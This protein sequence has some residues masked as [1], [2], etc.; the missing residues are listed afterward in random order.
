MTKINVGSM[1]N[2]VVVGGAVLHSQVSAGSGDPGHRFSE[3]RRA[4]EGI[5]DATARQ[6]LVQSA[7]DL[8]S[9]AGTPGFNDK[10]K[11]F[12]QLAADH[13]TVVSPFLPW[14]SALLA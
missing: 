11:Q 14:L 8:Q 9:A 5:R 13:M 12:M 10:Y 4:L 1:S 7:Q 6:Q 3:L 2:S